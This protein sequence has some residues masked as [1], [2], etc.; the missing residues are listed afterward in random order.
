VARVGQ[1]LNGRYRLVELLGEGGMAT[2]Y[3]GQDA[4]LGREVAV[5]VLR[6]EYGRDA[7]FVARF[8]QEAQSAAALNHPNVVNVHDFG[9][10]ATDPFIVMELVEGG[11]LGDVLREQGALQPIAAARIA[12]QMADALDAAHAQGIVHRDI[13]PTNVLITRGGRV[14]VADFGIA[15]AFSEAQLTMPGTTL[16]SVHYFSPEQ[17]RGELVTTASDVYSLGLVLFEMLTGR[18]AWTGD[19]AGA[20]AVARLAGDPPTASSVR[21]GVPPAL[22]G[23]VRAALSRAPADRPTAGEVSAALARFVADPSAPAMLGGVA[24]AATQTSPAAVAAAPPP[25]RPPAQAR[26]MPPPAPAY[27]TVTGRGRGAYPARPHEEEESG[28]GAWGWIAG[29][30]GV[31]VL[32]AG[33]V[34]LFLLLSGR[35]APN[36]TAGPSPVMVGVPQFVGQALPDAERAAEG[37]GVVLTVSGYQ[38]TTDAPENTILTQE[39]AAGETIQRGGR[40]Q[41]T[42]ATQRSTVVVPDLRL[43]TET[44]LV[45]ILLSTDLLPGTRS[46]AYDNDVPATLVVS[47]D[48]RANIEVARGT[49]INYVV[50][51]GPPPTEPPPTEPPPTEPPTPAP[52]PTEPPP[53]PTQ[54]T[55]PTPIT[56]IITPEPQTPIIITPPPAPVTPT[57]VLV[58]VGNYQC[59]PRDSAI[60]Q[61]EEGRLQVGLVWPPES[62]P[63]WL[64]RL[65]D[66]PPGTQVPEGSIVHLY[67]VPPAEPCS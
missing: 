15:R 50:S 62:Q 33:G 60:Q 67:V 54:A 57:P 41:V 14:K 32:L 37:A 29:I 13:K 1:V 31:L 43:R 42:V 3:R 51:Q 58:T 18:R 46:T 30:L 48:P 55:L 25:Y 63:D 36:S 16:G 40:V 6:A 12:Q 52:P 64:V 8:R 4:Q 34:L 21:P 49:V 27:G 23:I 22:D 61:I 59:Q 5:K 2:I 7:A 26:P 39:P 65:Q 10:E 66:P 9:M 56:I 11:D 45:E 20:V 53:P 47:T 28:S 17:A 24:A 44:E 19:S 35:G 38:Q